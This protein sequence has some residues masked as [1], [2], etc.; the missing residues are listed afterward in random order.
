[1]EPNALAGLALI[2]ALFAL[3]L[4]PGIVAERRGH[5]NK[6]AIIILNILL[7]WTVIGWI[8]ALVWSAT[9]V[10]REPQYS[11]AFRELAG[12]K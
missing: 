7:G 1:M 6:G 12:L 11:P 8:A 2:A 10:R 3:Y 5:H 4:L 9:A